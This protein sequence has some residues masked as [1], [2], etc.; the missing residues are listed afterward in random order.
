MRAEFMPCT[1][2][3]QAHDAPPAAGNVLLHRAQIMIPQI[4][5]A[6]DGNLDRS[7]VDSQAEA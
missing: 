4:P 5:A 6:C 1:D 2:L 7:N 3:I